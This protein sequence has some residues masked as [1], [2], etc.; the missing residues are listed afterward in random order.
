MTSLEG[1]YNGTKTTVDAGGNENEQ[2]NNLSR[3]RHKVEPGG[4]DL[5]QRGWITVRDTQ[6]HLMDNWAKTMGAERA[7]RDK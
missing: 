3:S 1:L 2:T 7:Q 4:G 6:C 5:R